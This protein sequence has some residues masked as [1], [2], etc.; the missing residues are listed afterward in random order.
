MG[1]GAGSNGG[2]SVGSDISVG[3]MDK[4][5]SCPECRLELPLT[6][7]GVAGGRAVACARCG[8]RLLGKLWAI[9]PAE[10]TNRLIITPEEQQRPLA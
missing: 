3:P 7:V 1:T 6:D 9:V 5:F 4:V 10:M 2:S 8:N